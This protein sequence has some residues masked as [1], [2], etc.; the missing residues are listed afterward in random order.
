MEIPDLWTF[1]VEAG[2][3]KVFGEAKVPASDVEHAGIGTC[4]EPGLVVG[5][6]GG[7]RLE[8]RVGERVGDKDGGGAEEA[9]FDGGRESMGVETPLHEGEGGWKKGEGGK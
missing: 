5:G 2:C 6:E 8:E 1:I 7:G 3:S 4:P 9:V